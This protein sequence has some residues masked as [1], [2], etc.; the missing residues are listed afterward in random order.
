MIELTSAIS[1]IKTM[2]DIAAFLLKATISTEV[3][4]KAIELQRIPP[5]R[6]NSD[7]LS[8]RTSLRRNHA[9]DINGLP[10]SELP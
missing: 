8:I 1:S 7:T 5:T 10:R 9:F 2:G 4:Q 6:K 3:T